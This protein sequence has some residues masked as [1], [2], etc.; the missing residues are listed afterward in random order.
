[1]MIHRDYHVTL[2]LMVRRLVSI[3]ELPDRLAKNT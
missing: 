1:M 3:Y 2:Q